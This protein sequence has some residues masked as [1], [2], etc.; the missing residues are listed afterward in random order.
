MNWA[1]ELVG[2]SALVLSG[3]VLGAV[4]L[5]GFAAITGWCSR[6]VCSWVMV[7]KRAS[8]SGWTPGDYRDNWGAEAGGAAGDVV[9]I[10]PTA[11]GRPRPWR[12]LRGPREEP[13][14]GEFHH[15]H[16]DN[17]HSHDGQEERDRQRIETQQ[18]SQR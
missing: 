17:D 4:V 9:G 18:A 6:S 13:L 15:D 10:R 8:P 16:V 14:L 12:L 1:G 3:H 5:R 7:T 2:I 11:G